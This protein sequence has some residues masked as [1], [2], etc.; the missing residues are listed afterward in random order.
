MSELT[1]E[2]L[3]NLKAELI[4]D[5]TARNYAAAQTAAEK[6]ALVN[7]PFTIDVTHEEPQ[8]ARVTQVLTQ[9]FAPNAVDAADITAAL[10][11]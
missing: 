4:N 5:P 11:S 9:P 10:A 1:Q 2:M 8:P 3:I 6:A 7:T